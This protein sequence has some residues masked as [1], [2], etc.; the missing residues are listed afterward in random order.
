MKD[1]GGLRKRG[2][3]WAVVGNAARLMHK[4]QMTQNLAS[5]LKGFGF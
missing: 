5:Y 2:E 3:T 1:G 4:V